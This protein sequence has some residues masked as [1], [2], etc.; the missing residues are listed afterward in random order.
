[1]FCM[2]IERYMLAF[3][4]YKYEM[5]KENTNIIKPIIYIYTQYY[6]ACFMAHVYVYIDGKN[7]FLNLYVIESGLNTCIE[8]VTYRK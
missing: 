3:I 6:H 7:F 1:M 2:F 8:K 5:E 4:D